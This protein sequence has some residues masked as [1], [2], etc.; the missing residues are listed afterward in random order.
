MQEFYINYIQ[1]LKSFYNSKLKTNYEKTKTECDEF[2]HKYE[3]EES[4]EMLE[5]NV[6]ECGNLL[7]KMKSFDLK[8]DLALKSLEFIPN[9]WVP[10]F[11]T[12]GQINGEN[13]VEVNTKMKEPEVYD[14][15]QMCSS[16]GGLCALDRNRLAVAIT[17]EAKEEEKGSIIILNYKFQVLDKIKNKQF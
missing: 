3:N 11:S 5:E 9:D 12:L 6:I 8:S 4:N 17:E 15:G 14:F 16:I 7:H 1:E 2:I 10:T 13:I